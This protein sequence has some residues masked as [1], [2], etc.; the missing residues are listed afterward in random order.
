[1]V[2]DLAFAAEGGGSSFE[3]STLPFIEALGERL[4]AWVDHHDSRHHE[5]FAAD[6]RFVLA[7]KAEHGACPEMITRELVRRVA[8]PDTIV[9]HGDFDGL[10]SAAKWMRGGEEPYRGC[11]DDARAV[12]TCTGELSDRGRRL[13]RALRARPR[14]PTLGAQV[15]AVLLCGAGDR[16]E[17]APIDAAGDELTALEQRALRLAS[18]YRKLG[19]DLVLVD[20][21][22]GDGPYDKTSLLLLGQRQ[23]RMAAVIDGDTVTFAAPFESG[24]DFVTS[25]GLS[26]GMPTRVSIRRSQLGAALRALGVPPGEIERIAPSGASST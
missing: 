16:A 2:L 9:C 7:T 22:G 3:R 14:D 24:I 15:L 4:L 8:Q 26:G 13:E 18:G 19:H 20:A 6:P 12:D 17:W 25:F 5:R 23:A 1:V 21:T 11:D 10:A